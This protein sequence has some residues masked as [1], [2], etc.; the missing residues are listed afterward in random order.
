MLKQH[1]KHE[2]VCHQQLFL[3]LF[4]TFVK[5]SDLTFFFCKTIFKSIILLICSERKRGALC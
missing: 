4:F 2:A 3:F 1:I 5:L